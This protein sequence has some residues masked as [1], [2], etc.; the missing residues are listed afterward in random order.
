[1]LYINNKSLLSINEGW[2]RKKTGFLVYLYCVN[3]FEYI[4]I[5]W[6]FF[7]GAMR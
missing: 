2:E 4:Y 3:F 7:G 1:M 5:V 6:T